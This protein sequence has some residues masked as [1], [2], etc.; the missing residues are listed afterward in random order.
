MVAHHNQPGD[1]ATYRGQ[2]PGTY[3]SAR[4][5]SFQN[6]GISSAWAHHFWGEAV[7]VFDENVGVD[8]EEII[9]FG[10]VVR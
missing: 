4:A 5:D 10:Q 3:L 8:V 1:P 7:C 2:E 6:G 9:G